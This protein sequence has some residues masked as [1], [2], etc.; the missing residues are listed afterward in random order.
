MKGDAELS[1]GVQS[2]PTVLDGL[3]GETSSRPSSLPGLSQRHLHLP[4]GGARTR[5]LGTTISKTVPPT[6]AAGVFSVDDELSGTKGGKG[7]SVSQP[8]RKDTS[9]SL[10]TRTLALDG[11]LCGG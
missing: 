11:C 10:E 2:R 6:L 1:D 9:G 7:F 4:E 8:S 5:A 3:R